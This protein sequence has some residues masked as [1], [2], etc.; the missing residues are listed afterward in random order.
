MQF[1]F[2]HCLYT[3]HH[4]YLFLLWKEAELQKKKIGNHDVECGVWTHRSCLYI[5]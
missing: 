5:W 1:A 4:N 2:H 3:E